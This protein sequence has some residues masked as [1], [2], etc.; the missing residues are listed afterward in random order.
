MTLYANER[1]AVV[2]S[3]VL[4]LGMSDGCVVR[5]A[6]DGSREPECELQ[7]ET[8][9]VAPKTLLRYVYVP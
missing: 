4:V 5:W 7:M 6:L 3:H 2:Q 1:Q 8:E 9:D